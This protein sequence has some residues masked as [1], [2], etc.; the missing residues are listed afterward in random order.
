MKT[1]RP[2]YYLP[3][4]STVSRDVKEVFKKVQSRIATML[5]VRI[6][7]SRLIRI[8]RPTHPIQEH[9]GAL[10]FGTDAWTSPNHK[11]YVAVTVHFEHKGE[12]MC[13]LLD[14]VEVAKSHS[15][16]NLASAFAKILTD[17]GIEHKVS[18]LDHLQRKT[19]YFVGP[20]SQ[21]YVRQCITERRDD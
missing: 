14:L 3:S 16:I 1:G 5:Q 12:V 10:S 7:V 13:I 6:H 20:D 17:F 15:S 8:I 4:A 2:D 21:C 19:T 11:A 9:E 18:S